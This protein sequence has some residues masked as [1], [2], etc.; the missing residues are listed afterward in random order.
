M[1]L[2]PVTLDIIWSRLIGICQEAE[3]A[4][5]RTAFSLQVR[6]SQ[7]MCCVLTDARG[8]AV[9]QGFGR[10][11]SIAVSVP[12]TVKNILKK[13][14]VESL[15][16][17][18][19]LITNLPWLATGHLWDNTVVE[20]VFHQGRLV[21]LAGSMAHWP[22]IGGRGFSAETRSIYEEGLQ[23]PIIKIA[24]RGQINEEVLA[25][26]RENVRVPEE[27]MGD[28][29]AQLVANSLT[30]TRLLELLETQGIADFDALAETVQ[31]RSE[32]AMRNAIGQIPDG[33]YEHEVHIDGFDRPI[34]IKVKVTVRDSDIC[35]DYSGSSEQSQYS[36]NSPPNYSYAYTFFA[37][38]SMVGPHLPFNSGPMRPV[39]V[40]LPL[41]TIVNPRGSVG[42]AARH[43]ASNFF[44]CAVLGALSKAIPQWAQAESVPLWP[45][46]FTG[47]T[48]SGKP[49]VGRGLLSSG[50]GGRNG[51]DGISC[52]FFPGNMR[53][54]P[55]ETLENRNPMLLVER[56]EIRTDSGGPGRYRGGCGQ[57]I[58][59]RIVG[60]ETVEFSPAVDRIEFPA[61]GIFGGQSGARGSLTLN[62]DAI[63]GKRPVTLKG[64]DLLS[65]RTPGGGGFG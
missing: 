49:F 23:L 24:K 2:D 34:I 57:H 60:K 65:L 27:V 15:E 47:H 61:Q 50:M 41:G 52:S 35:V 17:G 37:I 44:P 32:A 43:L 14:P 3:T 40:S 45:T 11:P 13:Y 16:P 6:E 53:S 42:M 8:D 56:R 39:S 59:Y 9:A 26:I 54:S 58:D 62:G 28:F 48:A 64:G 30:R 18:D 55:V 4:Q 7:D 51:K 22:D 19:I 63:G 21:A 38:K 1:R 31:A 25:I 5:M 20:P 46:A 33:D 36:I 10:L 12:L 29:R